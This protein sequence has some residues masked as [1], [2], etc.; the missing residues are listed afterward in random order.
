MSPAGPAP[1]WNQT[2]NLE[3]GDIVSESAQERGGG[4]GPGLG[5]FGSRFQGSR[6]K[7]R[8][9]FP[10][11]PLSEALRMGTKIKRTIRYA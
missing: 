1:G 2:L 6:T 3:E 11:L 7:Y 9:K 10:R 5:C 8:V 4:M